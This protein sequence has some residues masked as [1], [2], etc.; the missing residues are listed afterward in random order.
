MTTT[1]NYNGW[2]NRQ[3]WNVMLWINNEYSLYMGAVAY[4]KERHAKGKKGS[5]KGCIA[6]LG[7]SEDRTP[8]NIQYLS[9]RLD[10]RRLN[11]AINDLLN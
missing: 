11:E 8:D 9:T 10:Y 5:Y 7:L 1:E 4:M 3:T 6:Y 2:K